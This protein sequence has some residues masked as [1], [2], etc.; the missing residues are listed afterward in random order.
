LSKSECNRMTG[1]RVGCTIAGGLALA[2]TAVL[3]V[4]GNWIAA[5]FC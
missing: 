2:S 1:V 3:P 4:T 5:T